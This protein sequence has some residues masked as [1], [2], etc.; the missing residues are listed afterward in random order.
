[1]F[2]NKLIK[3]TRDDVHNIIKL[4]K[5]GK[6]VPL[7]LLFSLSIFSIF[8]EILGIS[9]LLIFLSIII[10]GETLEIYNGQ[11][12]LL[13]YF[14][15]IFN[16]SNVN[17]LLFFLFISFFL[18][19]LFK[20]FLLY[21]Q[22]N[23][24]FFVARELANR[25]FRSFFVL[26]INT[27]NLQHSSK[28][29]S[30]VNT[31][32]NICVTHILFPFISALT[33]LST[34]FFITIFLLFINFYVTISFL[35]SLGLIY[36]FILRLTK[37]NI[38]RIN[39]EIEKSDVEILQVIQESIKGI[40]EI[41]LN[42]LEEF[43]FKRFET[44]NKMLRDS[45]AS[46]RL[47]GTIPKLII[48]IIIF[49]NLII[50]SFI[51]LSFDV[52]SLLPFLGGFVLSMQRLLPALNQIYFSYT[53][54]SSNSKVLKEVIKF[55][56]V[57]NKNKG[58]NVNKADSKLRNFSINFNEVDFSYANNKNILERMNFEIPE[59]AKV[60]IIGDSGA[61]KSTLL[62]LVSG[63]IVPSVGNIKIGAELINE[64][65][66]KSYQENITYISQV[67]FIFNDTI[68]NNVSMNFNN[69]AKIK[70][71]IS[72]L[73]KSEIFQEIKQY[74]DGVKLILNENGINLSGGQRQ[75]ISLARAF[76]NPK[77]IMLF[78]E[79]TNSVDKEKEE[80]IVNNLLKLK[81]KTILFTSHNNL[82]HLKWDF[83][84]EVNKKNVV[85]KN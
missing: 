46:A 35:L 30:L 26:D 41:K 11:N 24:T 79:A 39:L 22:T 2:A 28:I 50:L 17:L 29:I 51:A 65:N 84:L 18:S 23:F 78:D 36:L 9:S 58:S 1:M 14:S 66:L 73:K 80:K 56:S 63:F 20:I 72:A 44:N 15:D 38:T 59:G 27:I 70:T 85:L 48:E 33:S 10:N 7:Y 4:F 37:E 45:Q 75:R 42:S 61:G 34:V 6:N 68:E 5:L 3:I 8:F 77:K 25:A 82:N 57:F 67:P 49:T 12:N 69:N 32:I 47:I 53:T 40:R 83:I 64:K 81:G 52:P 76:Y 71:I 74:K 13:N 16:L 21:I 55:I 19:F 60:L 62:D 54:F 43:L 31:K